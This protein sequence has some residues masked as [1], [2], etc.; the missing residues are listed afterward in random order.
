MQNL[1]TI[2]HSHPNGKYQSNLIHTLFAQ[3]TQTSKRVCVSLTIYSQNNYAARHINENKRERECIMSRDDARNIASRNF[4]LEGATSQVLQN[5]PVFPPVLDSGT[6]HIPLLA[7]WIRQLL[8]G[9]FRWRIHQYYYTK[10]SEQATPI[11][12]SLPTRRSVLSLSQTF[13][14]P[15]FN[16]TMVAEFRHF[17]R[18]LPTPQELSS[19]A[20]CNLP[21]ARS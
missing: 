13:V 12:R 16:V 21:P 9:C 6:P 5:K 11:W 17:H 8:T 19:F 15:W 1:H 2:S 7:N 3:T 4:S 20:R 14:L 10:V 18:I